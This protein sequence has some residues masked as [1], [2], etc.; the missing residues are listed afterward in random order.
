MI[1]VRTNQLAITDLLITDSDIVRFFA[2]IQAED[3][4]A[5]QREHKE[6]LV[7]ALKIGVV[8]L[9]RAQTRVDLDV[10]RREFDAWKIQVQ[11]CLD[12]I[13]REDQGKLALALSSY[14][15]EGGKL[16]DLFDPGR[17]ESAIG[18]IQAIFDEHFEGDGAKFARLLDCSEPGSPLGKLQDVLEKRFKAVDE[19]LTSLREQLAGKEARKEERELAPAKGFDFEDL[20]HLI[21]DQAAKPLRDTVALVSTQ[22]TDGRAKKG[23]LLIEVSEAA[24]DGQ[25]ACILIEAKRESKSIEGKTGILQEM[26]QAMANRQAQFAIAV[27][28]DDVCP[29]SVGR[30]RAYPKNRII[31]SIAPD[32]SDSLAL[33]VAYQLARTELCWQL[34]HEGRGIDQTRVAEAIRH[35]SEKLGQFKGLKQNATN[36]I[37]TA[38][39]IRQQLD[40]V[41]REIRSSLNDILAELKTED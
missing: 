11:D 27:F 12:D 29:N 2:D 24:T 34:R 31:C 9:Q 33:E 5:L 23:D 25:E 3:E 7:R 18:R 41:E 21:L 14:L 28:S 15:G 19:R 30:L 40:D 38:E 36:L 17:R 37:T 26:E 8:A 39:G 10:I 35:A 4:E 22:T 1:A 20:L 6:L 32:G 16:E 13:F